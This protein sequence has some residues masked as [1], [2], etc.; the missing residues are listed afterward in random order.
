[1][2]D[3]FISAVE[4]QCEDLIDK[5]AALRHAVKKAQILQS[6]YTNMYNIIEPGFSDL[7]ADN[8]L[9]FSDIMM[10]NQNFTG[11]KILLI[12]NSY[13]ANFPEIAIDLN[14]SYNPEEPRLQIRLEEQSVEFE[15]VRGDEHPE[16]LEDFQDI[17][18]PNSDDRARA[19]DEDHI[20][21]SNKNIL[22]QIEADIVYY[23]DKLNEFVTTFKDR[24]NLIFEDCKVHLQWP[25]DMT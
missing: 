2:R 7:P 8:F 15:I 12:S 19:K 13:P 14:I 17:G 10:S 6:V 1:M 20:E 23:T 24:I 25:E 18:N 3:Y 16:I 22:S 11:L 9:P 4:E 21:V 5:L